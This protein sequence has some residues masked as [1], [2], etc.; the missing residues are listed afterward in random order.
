M[1]IPAQNIDEI[2]PLVLPFYAEPYEKAGVDPEI[3][4]T[5][6][7]DG[8]L[9]LWVGWDADARAI[10]AVACS[11]SDGNTT[12]VHEAA[13][14]LSWALPILREIE[15]RAKTQG[16]TEVMIDGAR[17]GW[18]RHLKDYEMTRTGKTATYRRA[19]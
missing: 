4:K 7:I 10:G 8:V 17:L 9:Q 11:Q 13:G 5:A 16:D 19:L 1:P 12:R 6:L 14:G 15:A 18:S 3:L 2:W